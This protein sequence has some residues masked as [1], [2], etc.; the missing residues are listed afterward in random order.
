MKVCPHCSFLNEE[1][2]PTCV[3]CNTSIVDVP[4][5][6]SADPLHPEHEQ[7]ALAQ[8]RHKHLY[9]QLRSAVIIYGILIAVTAVTPGLVTN[10]LVLLL[11][12]ASGIVVGTAVT[13]G[14]A[15]QFSASLLQ[16][17][18]SLV[19]LLYFGPI[20]VLIFFMLAGHIILP[21]FLWHW[22]DLIYSANR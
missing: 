1:Q 15:G 20:H 12:F 18:L 9:R 7:R 8:Q 4:S 5:T 6:P 16:G 3:Y 10:A 21:G 14:I 22:V 19:L 11:Y 17:V 2:F 13:R